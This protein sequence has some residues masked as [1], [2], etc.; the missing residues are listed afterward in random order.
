[1]F[2]LRHPSVSGFPRCGSI[3]ACLALRP[4]PY[5]SNR[6]CRFPASGSPGRSR[7]RLTL[8]VVYDQ[9]FLATKSRPHLEAFSRCGAFSQAV[10][11]SYRLRH[12]SRKDAPVRAAPAARPAPPFVLSRNFANS[13]SN[14]P[15][16][17]HYISTSRRKTTTT[18]CPLPPPMNHLPLL[19]GN[20]LRFPVFDG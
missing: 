6:T 5:S 15:F 14:S 19:E 20:D 3:A 13:R 8:K 1:M 12:P 11:L 18:R 7:L 17:G 16:R 2:R 9:L 4:T 10:L